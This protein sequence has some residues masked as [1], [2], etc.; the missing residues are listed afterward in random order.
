[1]SWIPKNLKELAKLADQ[2]KRRKASRHSAPR[3]SAKELQGFNGK[4]S[5][6]NHHF[7]YV[8]RP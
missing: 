5:N 4:R 3:F 7:R 8:P 6:E 1:M 2:L